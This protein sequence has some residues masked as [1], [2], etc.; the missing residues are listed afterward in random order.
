LKSVFIIATVTIAMMGVMVPS[1]FAQIEVTVTPYKESHHIDQPNHFTV[2]LSKVIPNTQLCYTIEQNGKIIYF[3]DPIKFYNSNNVVFLDMTDKGNISG[4]G[5]VYDQLESGKYTV[6][7]YYGD[8][9]CNTE[10]IFGYGTTQVIFDK[11]LTNLGKFMQQNYFPEKMDVG[12]PGSTVNFS[13]INLFTSNFM[14]PPIALVESSVTQEWGGGI[15]LTVSKITISD[16]FLEEIKSKNPTYD[17]PDPDSSFWC[18][19][20]NYPNKESG[21][22]MSK[23]W[24]ATLCYNGD[25]AIHVFVEGRVH[26]GAAGN[27]SEVFMDVITK[28]IN[29][30]PIPSQFELSSLSTPAQDSTLQKTSDNSTLLGIASFVDQTKDP[31]NYV[32]RYNNEPEY[33]E[34]FDT[35]YPQYESIEQAVGLELTKKIP[36]WIKHIF[37]FYSQDK[38]SEYELLNAIQ[39]LIDEKILKIN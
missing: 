38:I 1:S 11:E 23:Y 2:E 18:D 33:K 5:S 30:N 9:Q 27:L 3:S 37:G 25:A 20:N 26:Q 32:D 22:K 28:K 19:T 35:N 39:Y 7:A 31:Q 6:S 24:K 29:S 8:G 14:G 4:N 10:N 17:N 15:I 36:T 34:W 13:N 12:F 16:D 21:Y